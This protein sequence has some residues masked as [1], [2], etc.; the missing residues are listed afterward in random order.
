MVKNKKYIKF[1]QL[2]KKGKFM[3]NLV[4]LLSMELKLKMNIKDLLV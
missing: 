2:Y 4:L 1:Y 3:M